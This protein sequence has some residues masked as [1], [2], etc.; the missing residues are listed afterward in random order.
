[1]D[2]FSRDIHDTEVVR[3]LSGNEEGGDW[4]VPLLIHERLL[5]K[6]DGVE[7]SDAHAVMRQRSSARVSEVSF[8]RHAPRASG[9]GLAR[10]HQRPGDKA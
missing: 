4:T 5:A 10:P 2:L 9:T 8:A 6:S 3:S 7:L 1:M